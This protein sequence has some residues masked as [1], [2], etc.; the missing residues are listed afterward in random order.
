MCI[1]CNKKSIVYIQ[2]MTERLWIWRWLLIMPLLLTPPYALSNHLHLLP[3]HEVPCLAIDEMVPFLPGAS[4]VYL[5]LFPFMWA[6]VLVQRDAVMA[7]RVV[8]S[9]AAC[10]WSASVLFVLLPT[11]YPRPPQAAGL[12]ALITLVDTPRNACPS[13]HGAYSIHAAAWVAHAQPTWRWAA[14]LIASAIL[15]ATIAVRQHGSLDLAAGGLL[16]L[17]AYKFARPARSA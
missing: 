14:C 3:A 9:A 2:P 1:S 11:A 4:W 6:A 13:L 16:G 10:A 17:V 8:L 12:H 7:R 15:L 5:G